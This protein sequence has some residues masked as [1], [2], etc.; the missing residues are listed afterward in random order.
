VPVVAL[1]LAA[2][3]VLSVSWL[4]WSAVIVVVGLLFWGAIY[5]FTSES[6]AYALLYPIGLAVLLYIATS[7]V[8]RGEQVQWK[9]RQYR[10][11]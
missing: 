1:L 9:Q 6:P 10:A 2:L 11:G 4:I 7:S 8:W 3:G 5:Q